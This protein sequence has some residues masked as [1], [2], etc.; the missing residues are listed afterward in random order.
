[1]DNYTRFLIWASGLYLTRYLTEEE[2]D[3]ETLSDDEFYDLLESL[4]TETYECTEGKDL[5]ELIEDLASDAKYHFNF[6]E[7]RL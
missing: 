7:S 4:A 1:M 6:K 3:G 5:F 2:I